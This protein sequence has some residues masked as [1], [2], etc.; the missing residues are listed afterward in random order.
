M[1]L[2]FHIGTLALICW[3]KR[4]LWSLT[5]HHYNTFLCNKILTSI[6]HDNYKSSLILPS[7]LVTDLEN[8]LQFLIHHPKVL[9]FMVLW[10]RVLIL[11]PLVLLRSCSAPFVINT[12]STLIRMHTMHPYSISAASVG[13]I[14]ALKCYSWCGNP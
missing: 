1:A 5:M 12:I 2:L 13:A 8:K 11:N 14:L 3:D 10:M 4:L 6:R 7:Q 9:S